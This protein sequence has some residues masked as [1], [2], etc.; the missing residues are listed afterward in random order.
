MQQG[1][2]QGALGQL[3]R[4]ASVSREAA[5]LKAACLRYL[6]QLQ[7]ALA[8]LDALRL[9]HPDYARVWQ[10]TGHVQRARGQAGAALK[11][12]RQAVTLNPALV[13][14]WQALV[15]LEADHGEPSAA[16]R[17][18]NQLKR[19][20]ALP[21]ELLTV[22]SLL[23]EGRLYKAEQ[24]CRAF[25]QRHPAHVE[26]MRLLAVLGV[27][28]NVLDDAEYLLETA[29]DL[30]PRNAFVRYDYVT[31]LARRQKFAQAL[32]EA[33]KLRRA[34]P[35]N[36]SFETAY[37]NQLMAVGDFDRALE[38]YDT[39]LEALPDHPGVQLSRGHALKTKGDRDGAVF[40]YQA[41]R[42]IRPQFG[43][44]WWSL[45]NLKTY[46][47]DR[48]E[49]DQM[50]SLEADSG[51]PSVDRY[52]LCFALGK[53]LEDVGQY[54]ES[55]TYYARGNELK[56]AELRYDPERVSQEVQTQRAVCTA[57]FLAERAEWG[58]PAA[59]PIFV[60]G[61]PRAGSTLIEQ[62]LASHSQ[63]DGTLELP[64]VLALVHRLNGRLK[65]DE[66]PHY[67]QVLASLTAE[68][69]AEFGRAFIEDTQLHRQ[70]APY[71]IDKMPN[72]FRHIGLIALMLPNARFIDAR[73]H[74][75]ACCFSGF[76]QLFAEGQEFS[77]RLEDIGR[78]YREY[79]E[80][81]THWD[82]ALPRRVLRVDYEAVVD[83][84][85][86]QVRRMLAFLDLP[87]EA[88]CLEFHRTQRLVRTASAE[89]VRQPINT[90]GVAQWRHYAPW[91]APLREALGAQG[92]D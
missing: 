35:G 22:T 78:Y 32:E 76:K 72:N 4:Q 54:A 79:V 70:G 34:Q 13:A 87:F 55:W 16:E 20:Q 68:Q 47:F 88:G 3:N 50:R 69:C 85:E 1:D 24:L 25:L 81:M 82:E 5:F 62:I 17:A 28:L 75:M 49:L 42:H 83:D 89:Q 59:D 21:R 60:V 73:R 33:E 51:L 61:L 90:Q 84:L 92:G 37:A 46:S 41:A 12:Y 58:D 80:L 38:V 48:V 6:G 39:V 10:E 18:S 56:A 23:H 14:S 52:H 29:L 8:E 57:E 30:D 91:L 36:P 40:A 9:S 19:L 65:R 2:F 15:Q 63:V 7:L 26:G 66:T 11:A 86:G 64:N 53:A 77:Y 43:D 74:P 27:Q 45:A 67:P 71:F 44:A 31:V